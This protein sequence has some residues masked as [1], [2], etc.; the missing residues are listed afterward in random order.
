MAGA[1]NATKAASTAAAATAN[2]IVSF[3]RLRSTD[4]STRSPI[5]QCVFPPPPAENGP[6]YA[7]AGWMTNG[8]RDV[9]R[10]PVRAPMAL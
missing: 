9:A 10:Q 4:E 1:V 2:R 6:G 5:S 8:N 3:C 7:L